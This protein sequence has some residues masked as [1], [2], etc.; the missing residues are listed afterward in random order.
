MKFC[1]RFSKL[2]RG[3]CVTGLLLCIAAA[4]T[5]QYTP[6]AFSIENVSAGLQGQNVIVTG[7]VV[8]HLPWKV[9]NLEVTVSFQDGQQEYIVTDIISRISMD[10]SGTFK[11]N[12]HIQNLM[13]ASYKVGITDF[14]ILDPNVTRLLAWFSLSES[15]LVRIKIVEAFNAMTDPAILPELEECVEWPISRGRNLDKVIE[16]ILCLNGLYALQ[17]PESVDALLTLM[18]RYT[19]ETKED[20]LGLVFS[21][22]LDTPNSLLQVMIL[23]QLVP[24]EGAMMTTADLVEGILRQLGPQAWPHLL[25]ATASEDTAVAEA[26]WQMI[27]RLELYDTERL[28]AMKDKG[29]S[30]APGDLQSGKPLAVWFTTLGNQEANPRRAAALY[31]AALGYDAEA[32]D[33]YQALRAIILKSNLPYILAG[34]G[35][36]ILGLWYTTRQSAP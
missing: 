11:V 15:G 13:T 26:A 16:D 36:L 5:A 3:L 35:I 8:N 30:L 1:A 25:R 10:G 21:V 31:D 4:A 14:T 9:R 27:E 22:G 7:Q 28:L 24:E 2:W 32:Q 12:Q 33:A 29:M 23:K 34:L 17:S 6:T 19:D 20:D 18:A